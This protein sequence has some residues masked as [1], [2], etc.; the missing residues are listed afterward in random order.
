M[1]ILMLAHRIPYPPH[2]GDKI[3]AYQ[4]A[5]HLARGHDLTLGFVIDDAGDRSGLDALRRDIPDLEWG[6]LW[7]PAA[8]ARGL[9]GLGRGRSLSI[10]YFR[11]SRLARRVARRLRDQ[12]YDAVYVS[13]SPMVEYV[14]GTAL[15]VVMDFVDV[16]SDKWAQYARHSRPPLSWLYRMEGRR[17]QAA[18]AA[19]AR[20][21][22]LC[23]LATS[24]EETLLRSFAPWAKTAVI[25]N[26]IDL[27]YFRPAE[28]RATAPGVIF[29]GAMDYMPNVDA[30]RYFCD[31]ILPRVRREVPDTRFYI[32]G[33]NPTAE[34]R[35]LADGANVIVTGTVP[36]VRPY[37]ERAS[38]CVAPLRIGRGVQNKV[39][40]AMALGMPVVASSVAQRGLLAEPGRHLHVE[41]DPAAFASL[42]VRLL[43][44]P[45]E[46]LAMGR[47][48]RAF[49][50]GHH[51]WDTSGARLDAMIRSL[52]GA[53]RSAVRT[54]A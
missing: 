40:Q 28:R 1:R 15:P 43:G 19:I 41:D 18:E 47:R 6:S 26:G 34:V 42:V 44:S 46:R 32:V 37:Y 52:G 23:L 53:A 36:D 11:S 9:A 35:A 33:L 22:S 12:P 51:A 49:V 10:A 50:E 2:T 29:T 8:V 13:S 25:P 16:D 21:A 3:R 30:V 31:E 38:V 17:L 39:L 45:E 48:A 20:W 5:R 14:R 7:K 27:E 54:S 24:A 4:I